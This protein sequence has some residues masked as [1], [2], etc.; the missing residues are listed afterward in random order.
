MRLSRAHHPVTVLGWG[1]RAGLWTQGCSIRCRGCVARD[2]WAA[3]PLNEV[4]TAAIMKWLAPL[5]PCDG[6]TISGGEPLDQ[7]A[8]LVELLV[9]VRAARP[10]G[11]D[12]LCYTGRTAAAARRRCPEV[13]GLV[14]ALAV[15]PFD[16][17]RPKT[18]PL[19]GSANQE[20]VLLTELGEQRYR[21]AGRLR[22]GLQ[23]TAAGSRL[24]GIG[25]PGR[26]DLQ[27]V[28]RGAARRGVVLGE[29]SW[30]E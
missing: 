19:L 5:A 30:T 17:R 3:K 14:D 21:D 15:G 20:L 12:I 6:L 22:G 11:F 29:Q 23:A 16:A 4:P 18:H 24:Y 25:V 2:T 10:A 28:R 7:A 27:A 8:A 13:F 1:V 26:G 9:Q